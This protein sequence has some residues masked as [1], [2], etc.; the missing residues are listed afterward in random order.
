MPE[1]T[2]PTGNF[3]VGDVAGNVS[4]Q[5]AGGDIVT[6][7]K[8]VINQIIQQI[9]EK[10]V[11]APYKFLAAYDISDRD[12]F[13]GRDAIIADL[14]GKVPR[15][16]VL[17]INGASGSGKS[18]LVNAG[19]IPRLADNGYSYLSFRD[20]H[21]P[22]Q[23]LR[24]YTPTA[25]E[26]DIDQSLLTLI[27]ACCNTSHEHI[28]I[29]LDQFERFFV[30]VPMA[31]RRDFI[32][33]FQVALAQ[34]TAE[35]M[36]FVIILRHEFFGRLITEF[37]AVIPEF[38]NQAAHFNL[39]P[40]SLVEARDAIIKPLARLEV[41]IVYDETF[42]DEVLIAGLAEQQHS[43]SGSKE[44][45][46]PH[47][48][49]VCNAL[50][51]AAYAKL[52]R[53]QKTAVII[54]Q[55]LYDSLGGAAQ[56]LNTYLDKTL[57]AIASAD[58]DNAIIRSML[59]VMINSSGTR[60]F[61]K[62]EQLAEA[63]PDVPIKQLQTL[64]DKLCEA[65]IVE[66][67]QH[68]YSLSHEVMVEKVRSWFDERE[69]VRQQA[70]ETLARGLAEWRA[71]KS[72]LNPQQLSKIQQWLPNLPPDASQLVKAS[73]K[74]QQRQ[75]HLKR[76]SQIVGILLLLSIIVLGIF[77]HFQ[78]EQ[79]RAQKLE[80]DTQRLL[81]EEKQ[82]QA[83]QAEQVALEQRNQAL[84]TQ[85][86][87]L[88][89][90][91]RQQTL[92]GNAT[93]GLLLALEALPIKGGFIRPY[94][95]QAM[96]QLYNAV[97]QPRER[98]VLGGRRGQINQLAFDSSGTQV[99]SASD[100][101]QLSVW[102]VETGELLHTFD[103]YQVEVNA[104]AFS[105]DGQQL[106][107]GDAG[108]VVKIWSLVDNALLNSW[109]A[110]SAVLDNIAFSQTGQRVIT[111]ATAINALTVWELAPETPIPLLQVSLRENRA[112][113]VAFSPEGDFVLS[114]ANNTAQ[115]RSVA[116][117]Q[118]AFV[119]RGH[120]SA[121]NVAHWSPDGK[122]I[123]TAGQDRQ[124][125]LWQAKTGRLTHTF[126]QATAV[127][128]VLF[129]GNGQHLVT[130]TEDYRVY[131]WSI[132][133]QTLIA[134]WTLSSAAGN[135]D[136]PDTQLPASLLPLHLSEDGE[137][138]IS[139]G[140]KHRIQVWSTQMGLHLFTLMGHNS[141]DVVTQAVLNGSKK[142]LATTSTDHRIRLWQMYGAQ[143]I[144]KLAHR[145]P[146]NYVAWQADS[147]Q[148][149]SAGQAGHIYI[150]NVA[151]AELLQVLQG[152]EDSV[153]KVAFNPQ[154]QAQLLS[155]A[156][157]GT[158]KL[159]DLPTSTAQYTLTGHEDRLLTGAYSHN[160]QV[161]VTAA[162]NG[163]ARLWDSMS[164]AILHELR[165]HARAV[166]AVAFSPNDQYLATASDDDSVWIWQ[167]ADGI[168]HA[169]LRGHGG[170]VRAV[171]F[172][173]DG[174][175][176]A[177]VA[178][179][180]TGRVWD[181]A[182]GQELLVLDQSPLQQVTTSRP[183]LTVQFLADAQ[184]LVT[185]GYG[186]QLQLWDAQA[187]NLLGTLQGYNRPVQRLVAEQAFLLAVAE[188]GAR[189]WDLN[190]APKRRALANLQGNVDD[191]VT[192]ATFSPDLKW[193]ALTS[194]DGLVRLIPLFYDSDSLVD[195]ALATQARTLTP[196]QRKWFFLA[197]K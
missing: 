97:I 195:Q 166:R 53:E 26:P 23:Q 67:R 140:D 148:L 105:P 173:P 84:R 146:Q 30:N 50:Y 141:N 178:E 8:T 113:P 4:I 20:Y 88:A 11:S 131:H 9:A 45:D 19:L 187:G 164:G 55:A 144:R 123:V 49:I 108:G 64:L 156:E 59:K 68:R 134:E 169:I 107:S 114:L 137:W 136:E 72:L 12:I 27:Q 162:R 29:F 75:Q 153:I 63:L 191:A 115:I 150:W 90:L 91:A 61:V 44:I 168:V 138:L 179:D 102:A 22:L 33:A 89:D 124:T 184:Q 36:N 58:K 159:W 157:D 47:L 77:S 21:D 111:Q 104:L 62:T 119:L 139:L 10:V 142:W 25:T 112:K 16:K 43:S 129:S 96:E 190:A 186:N 57:A 126:D 74:A 152:H 171:T 46:P 40:L 161:V 83:Q 5:Q 79:A 120:R 13:F 165:G 31:K 38:L 160:G 132:P 85:S 110:H 183:L 117:Q 95:P 92:Q 3:Q 99:A 133:D 170:D 56:I 145:S 149:A 182:N 194:T 76:G 15:Y 82:Q 175:R 127:A 154:Q 48:Q 106:A 81:A 122:W 60:Q 116:T 18:S 100:D 130:L 185:A 128:Q 34:T 188:D 6:G 103:D 143:K 135:T 94:V 155:I 193:V 65:R 118:L 176:L 151:D 174:T 35:E 42:V 39:Q 2:V 54:N 66:E 69:M 181:V 189:L 109:Q 121:I 80:A 7:D 41:K 71:S 98:Y 180:G 125:K 17:I 197:P 32:Q 70:K 52:T 192:F 163:T 1:A 51:E 87:F 167:V 14:V 28:V 73:Q 24:E 101:G 147:R 37:E 172:N 177:S 86:L 78:A 158:A 196:Q 93:N